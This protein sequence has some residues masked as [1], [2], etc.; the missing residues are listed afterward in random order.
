[1]LLKLLFFGAVCIAPTLSYCYWSGTAPCCRG[2]CRAGETRVR[3]GL[4]GDGA[5][6]VG[7][8][9][10]CSGGTKVCCCTSPSEGQWCNQHVNPNC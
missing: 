3:T 7:V 6:C 10:V 2:S 5:A 9:L 4:C 8:W 1:M